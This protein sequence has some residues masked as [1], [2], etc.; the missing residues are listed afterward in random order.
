MEK[1]DKLR[2]RRVTI[3]TSSGECKKIISINIRVSKRERE[4]C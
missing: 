2:S 1:N 3:K 4:K